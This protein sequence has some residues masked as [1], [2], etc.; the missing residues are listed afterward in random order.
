MTLGFILEITMYYLKH[1]LIKTREK[2]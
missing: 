1:I 2:L